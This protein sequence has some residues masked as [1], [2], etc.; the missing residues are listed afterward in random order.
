MNRFLTTSFSAA[1][2]ALAL[3]GCGG[4]DSDS[5]DNDPQGQGE[6][7]YKLTFTTLWNAED[8]PQGFPS[9]PHFSPLVGATHN[10]Q[11]V[12]WRPLDQQSTAGIEQVAET[13]GTSLFR[14]EL[15]ERKTQGYVQNILLAGGGVGSP[16]ETVLRFRTSE[17]FPLLSII[18][19][20]APSP[21]WFVGLR[22]VN[23]REGG[24]WLESATFN[25][26]L[27]D[28]GTDLGVAFTSADSDGGDGIIRLLS[29]DVSD[30]D[31]NNGVHRSSGLYVATMQLQ[32]E[33]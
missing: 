19:M 14:A 31:F 15:Q 1:L 20:I 2:L 21:D 4:N 18:S 23:L 11:T 24:E 7:Q 5:S 3:S 13:G 12:I 16:G 8:F 25:L 30:T 27:Y 33:E 26:A 10:E 9:N 29:S 6:V 28:A 32:R 22:D 17:Q